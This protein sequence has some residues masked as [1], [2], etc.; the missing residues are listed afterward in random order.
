MECRQIHLK[1]AFT[2]MSSARK[3]LGSLGV[4]SRF[5]F[6]MMNLRTIEDINAVSEIVMQE[7]NQ[8]QE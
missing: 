2:G 7:K 8:F 1:W 6:K 3:H 5:R 4:E